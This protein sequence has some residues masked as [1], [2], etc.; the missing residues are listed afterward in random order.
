MPHYL[1]YS[2]NSLKEGFTGLYRETITE[3]IKR[4]TRSL[5]YSS[6]EGFS[7]CGLRI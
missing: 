4:D 2:P 3:L 5:D 1:S 7:V 6:F